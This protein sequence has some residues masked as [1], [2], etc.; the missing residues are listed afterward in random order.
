MLNTGTFRISPSHCVVLIGISTAPNVLALSP[1]QDAMSYMSQLTRSSVLLMG[2][3]VITC[4][5]WAF[6][7]K[8]VAKN[9]FDDAASMP[10]AFMISSMHRIIS[11]A[12]PKAKP[13]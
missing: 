5:C 8:M 2:T 11:L 13:F 4:A 9:K 1:R 10:V 3:S 12:F 6:V 7:Q